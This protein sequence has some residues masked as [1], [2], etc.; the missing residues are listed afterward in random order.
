MRAEEGRGPSARGFLPALLLSTAGLK[1]ALAWILPGFLTGDDVEIVET[2][3]KYAVGLDYAPSGIRSMFHPLLLAWAPVRLGVA[4]G[5]SSPHWLTFLACVPTIVFST[6]AIA[7]VY[8]LAIALGWSS[9]AARAAAFLYAVHWL[10]L[11]YGATQFPRPISTCLLLMAFLLLADG[12]GASDAPALGA[13]ALAAAAM[14]VRWSEATMLVPLLCFAA[15]RSRRARP[16]L[17]VFAGF[18]AA[19]L[20]CVGVLWTPGP[21]AALSP[22]SSSSFISRGTRTSEGFSRGPPSGT[23]RWRCSGRGRSSCS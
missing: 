5:L 1:L 14:A 21:G 22:A 17:L 11:G 9:S 7:V 18:L 12:N 10:A 19:S 2:A 20:V 23:R 3:A 6:V 16:A 15:G 8:R 4:V 13:G